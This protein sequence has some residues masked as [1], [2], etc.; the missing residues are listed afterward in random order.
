[1]EVE[2]DRHLSIQ[3][4]VTQHFSEDYKTLFA[5]VQ[6]HKPSFRGTDD[7]K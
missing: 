1:M 7:K 2:R 5:E 4:L 3:S 6:A